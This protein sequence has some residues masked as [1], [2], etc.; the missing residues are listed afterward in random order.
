MSTRQLVN[1]IYAI[2]IR[3]LDSDDRAELDAALNDDLAGTNT[4]KAA[5]DQ[6]AASM[7]AP[8]VIGSG[9]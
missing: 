1:V 9:S 8:I 4:R 7:G 6:H 2:L 5:R 3:H